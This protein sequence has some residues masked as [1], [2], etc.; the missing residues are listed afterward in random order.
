MRRVYMLLLGAAGSLLWAVE[1]IVV[2]F[3]PWRFNGFGQ[4]KHTFIGRAGSRLTLA[5]LSLL[6]RAP[7]FGQNK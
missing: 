6:L 2:V 7:T 1:H 3:M 4:W 5:C